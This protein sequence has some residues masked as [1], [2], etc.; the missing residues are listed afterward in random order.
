MKHVTFTS[1][2]SSGRAGE[3]RI[4]P[5]EIAFN[6]MLSGEIEPSPPDWPEKPEII[7]DEPE[8]AAIDLPPVKTPAKIIKPH[9]RSSYRTK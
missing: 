7:F 6:L 5:D 8:P 4:V 3:R 2:S 9:H 1:A